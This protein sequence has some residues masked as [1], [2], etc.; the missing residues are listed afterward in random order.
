M[1]PLEKEIRRRLLEHGTMSFAEFMEL[2]LYGSGGYYSRP[3]A[4]IGRDR[5]FVTGSSMSRLFGRATA[6]VLARLA[7]CLGRADYLEI[8]YGSGEHL[9]A[10][11][12]EVGDW[13]G[14]LLG[15]DRGGRPLPAPIRCVDSA[16]ALAPGAVDG[17][18]FSYELFDALAV[19]RLVGRAAGEAAELRVALDEEGR[20]CWRQQQP[21][22]PELLALLGD[23]MLE[24]GQIA[25]L[26]LQWGPLYTELASRLGRGLIVTFDYGF[27]RPRLLDARIRPYGTL[28]CY[29]DQRAHR[30]ALRDPGAQDLTAH[31]DFT[32][33]RQAGEALGLQ[34]ISLS[35]QARWLAA[36]GIFDDLSDGDLQSREEAMRLL[37]PQGMGE[38][39]R[40]LVQGRQ[41]DVERVLDLDVLG[42]FSGAASA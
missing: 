9:L 27:E 1:S 30:D 22:A 2:S 29:R 35:R 4:P 36:A 24:E 18:I 28:A 38:E 10:V 14:E 32:A 5:D 11:A 37:D 21:A 25:D 42:A 19:N 8:G 20:L 15:C 13:P 34:T 31:V 16:A 7:A 3:S 6:R 12:A 39:I 17:L 40:V 26:S 41:V 23:E 33:L